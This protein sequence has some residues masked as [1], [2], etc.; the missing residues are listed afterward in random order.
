ML[1]NIITNLF[2][3]A[4]T[5]YLREKPKYF[6]FPPLLVFFCGDMFGENPCPVTSSLSCK[7]KA[8]YILLAHGGRHFFINPSTD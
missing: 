1:I 2:R 6:P 3:Q 4:I 8:A 5:E 7:E